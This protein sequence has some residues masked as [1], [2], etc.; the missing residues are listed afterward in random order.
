MNLARFTEIHL[1]P[2]W[3]LGHQ[4]ST[5]AT[6]SSNRL[7]E[8]RHDVELG[9]HVGDFDLA[10]LVE[11]VDEAALS[12]R[13][14]LAAGRCGRAVTATRDAEIWRR[15]ESRQRRRE[16]P[17]TEPCCPFEASAAAMAAACPGRMEGGTLGA[18]Q[19]TSAIGRK[20]RPAD[21][22]GIAAVDATRMRDV[23]V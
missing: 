8:A 4:R 18:Q 15:V 17:H 10:V 20:Q 11:H 7:G 9:L 16:P 6:A 3:V 19:S 1:D 14:Q 21:S 13:P 2:R 23:A 12:A 22:S 5:S